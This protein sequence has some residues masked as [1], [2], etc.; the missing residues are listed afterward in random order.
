MFGAGAERSG[1]PSAARGMPGVFSVNHCADTGA[2]AA[3]RTNVATRCFMRLPEFGAR[4]SAIV[5]DP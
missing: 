5:A 4:L 2:T 3:N 1:V